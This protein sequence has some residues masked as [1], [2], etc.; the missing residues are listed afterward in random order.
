MPIEG[1]WTGGW[2]GRAT[3]VGGTRRGCIRGL[4]RR[5]PLMKPLSNPEKKKAKALEPYSILIRGSTR[6]GRPAST[7]GGVGANR[8]GK[9]S[10]LE[11]PKRLEV[12]T[13]KNTHC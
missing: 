5:Q 6:K 3:S 13:L 4:G 2:K 12:F 1:N 10:D 8:R 11:F 9:K 7:A